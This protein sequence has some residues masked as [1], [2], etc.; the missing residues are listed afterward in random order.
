M[1]L[2]FFRERKR[3]EKKKGKKKKK[4]ERKDARVAEVR[5]F[6]VGLTASFVFCAKA[7]SFRLCRLDDAFSASTKSVRTAVRTAIRATGV[8]EKGHDGHSSREKVSVAV[9]ERDEYRENER[10]YPR[11]GA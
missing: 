10:R 2:F 8:R 4:K 11:P 5:L 6:C 3:R 7:R 1:T 9:R